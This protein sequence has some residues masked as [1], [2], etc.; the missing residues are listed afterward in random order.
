MTTGGLTSMQAQAMGRVAVMMGG[1]S[2]EREI[3][4][5]SGQAVL[6]ALQRSG[7]DA[8][9]FDPS[10]QGLQALVTA[11]V[12]RV[13]LALHG[14][15]GEDGTI[16]GALEWLRIPYTGSGV[17]ASAVAMDKA[18]TKRLWQTEALPTPLFMLVNAET[19]PEEVVKRLG[20]PVAIKPASEGSSIGF[21]RV[22]EAGQIPAAIALAQQSGD[23]VLAEQFISGR[24]FTC[25]LIDEGAPG[26]VQALPVIE[27]QAPQGNYDYQHKYFGSETQYL[28]PAPL[29]ASVT[30]QMQ[31]LALAAYR[32]LDCEGWARVDLM[33]DGQGPPQLLELNTTPG[34]TDHSLVPMAAKQA[35][36]DFDQLV[37]KILSGAR[38]KTQE[39]EQ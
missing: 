25:A 9:S 17:K 31:A 6:A 33:W 38:L 20:L 13:F 30:H 3:S 23:D 24:E 12:D 14:R 39:A 27:I 7:V 1:D 11:S 18:M 29:S 35:G 34:M 26:R 16:Q 28:C 36:L 4:L 32:S 2:A 37:M 19:R 22:D 5:R 21:S 8:F 15:F 10:E